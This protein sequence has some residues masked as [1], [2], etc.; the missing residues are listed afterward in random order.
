MK[1]ALVLFLLFSFQNSFA[2]NSILALVNKEIITYN[3]IEKKL[4]EV[5][6]YDEKLAIINFRIDTILQLKK[7]QEFDIYPLQSDINQTIIELAN[8]NNISLKELNSRSDF[9]F[10]VQ[11]V[12][13]K[14]AVLNLQRFVTKDLKFNLSNDELINKCPVI[15]G[16]SKIKQI[17]I[18]QIII[19]QIDNT[20]ISSENMDESIKSFLQKLSEHISKGASFK[21]SAKLHSQHSSYLNGGETDWIE[22][23]STT[24][25]MLD[26]L[27]ENEVSNIYLTDFGFAIG[28]KLAERFVS[29][30]LKQCKEKLT[31]LNA[32]K[33]YSSWVK[34]LR[35]KAYI[36]IYYDAL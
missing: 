17:K 12:S 21:A 4:N 7:T 22:V 20:I 36:K 3:S 14:L 11:E 5:N 10:I 25:K 24:V 30:E 35:D 34:E 15:N 18:A 13:T 1:R 27:K 6:T 32:E 26:S 19:S 2:E 31:Y 33:F 23:D 8:I 28:I 16:G 29:S 9:D